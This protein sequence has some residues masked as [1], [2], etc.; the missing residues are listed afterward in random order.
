MISKQAYHYCK[1]RV[2]NEHILM[3]VALQFTAGSMFPFDVAY[4]AKLL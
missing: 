1:I 4:L 2:Y 3:G